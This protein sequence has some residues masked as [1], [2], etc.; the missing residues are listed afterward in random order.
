MSTETASASRT[1]DYTEAHRCRDC[2]KTFWAKA[3]WNG[4]NVKCPHC[5]QIN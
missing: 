3:S 5:G 2:R 4:V 1:S